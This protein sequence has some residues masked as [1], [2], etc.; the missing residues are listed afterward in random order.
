MRT[1]VY[2]MQKI[3]SLKRK[4]REEE[5]GGEEDTKKRKK[6]ECIIFVFQVHTPQGDSGFKRAKESR[7]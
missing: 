2:T 6:T 5:E 3:E 7:T 4:E 1:C